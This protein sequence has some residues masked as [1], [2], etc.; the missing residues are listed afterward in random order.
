MSETENGFDEAA[1]EV[2]KVRGSSASGDLGNAWQ[3]RFELLCGQGKKLM[4][5]WCNAPDLPEEMERA[6]SKF[7]DALCLWPEG[8]H[9]TPPTPTPSEGTREAED[10]VAILRNLC[11]YAMVSGYVKNVEYGGA[12]HKDWVR[13]AEAYIDGYATPNPAPAPGVG[14]LKNEAPANDAG[15][16]CI[17]GNADC[18]PVV[19]HDDHGASA[20][21]KCWDAEI[22]AGTFDPPAPAS[23]RDSDGED[24]A[25]FIEE[26]A[27]AINLAR[28]T[29]EGLPPMPLAQEDRSS[30]EYARRLAKAAATMTKAK[31]Q[32]CKQPSCCTCDLPR[33]PVC[34]YT[35]HDAAF[36][37]DHGMCKGVIPPFQVE[38]AAEPGSEVR[39]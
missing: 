31:S 37:M 23:G 12:S 14:A 36:H 30:Q 8:R 16:R 5:S 22:A 32:T 29:P 35:K 6:L 9:D 7:E 2:R 33:C 38:A 4:R 18:G 39:S 25:V 10:V 21:Q 24:N 13:R 17:F 15:E 20:C 3:K 19:A 34:G 26:L 27:E 28:Y 1:M 11:S